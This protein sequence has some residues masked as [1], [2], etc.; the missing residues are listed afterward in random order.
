MKGRDCWYYGST[1]REAWGMKEITE[2]FEMAIRENNP[3]LAC[4][5]ENAG[6]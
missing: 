1:W 2:M 4:R 5:D 3:A 6:R